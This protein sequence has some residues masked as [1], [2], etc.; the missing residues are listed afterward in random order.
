MLQ[1]KIRISAAAAHR[2]GMAHTEKKMC[3]FVFLDPHCASGRIARRMRAYA[4]ARHN[5]HTIH[6]KTCVLCVLWWYTDAATSLFYVREAAAAT[7]SQTGRYDQRQRAKQET[8]EMSASAP[9]CIYRINESNARVH[10]CRHTRVRTTTKHIS[11]ARAHKMCVFSTARYS[12][13]SSD[14]QAVVVARAYVA[15]S[16]MNRTN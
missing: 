4:L 9:L 10:I 3:A 11:R 7:R 6:D 5:L 12:R 2:N 13:Q 16:L 15:A 14:L 1:E 8:A